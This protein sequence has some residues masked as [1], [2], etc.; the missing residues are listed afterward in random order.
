MD[1]WAWGF[2]SGIIVGLAMGLAGY[3]ILKAR[4]RG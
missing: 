1:A 3:V 2:L 4:K